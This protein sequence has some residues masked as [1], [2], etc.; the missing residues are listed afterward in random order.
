ME[1]KY[2]LFSEIEI[3]LRIVGDLKPS[4]M[5]IKKFYAPENFPLYILITRGFFWK[6]ISFQGIEINTDI[7]NCI[8]NYTNSIKSLLISDAYLFKEVHILILVF[9]RDKR[10]SFENIDVWTKK[11]KRILGPKTIYLLVGCESELE[12]EVSMDEAIEKALKYDM[13]YTEVCL[14]TGKGIYE[15]FDIVIRHT[16]EVNVG[17]IID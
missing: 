1:S 9:D 7:V 8:Q 13:Y 15:M 6:F 16:F 14:K 10:Q 2:L 17:P 12:S 11:A 4:I 3:K 5:S